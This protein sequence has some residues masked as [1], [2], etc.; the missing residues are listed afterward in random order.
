M[1]RQILINCRGKQTR[2]KVAEDL[3][4]TPQMLG[5]LERGDRTPSLDLANK[6]SDYYGMPIEI[7]FF[8]QDGNKSCLKNEDEKQKV[9][10]Y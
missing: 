2:Q 3:N 1:K 5:M 9:I 6:I 7:L 8:N 10:Q 4:I